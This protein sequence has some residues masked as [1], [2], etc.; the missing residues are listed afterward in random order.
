LNANKRLTQINQFV[1]ERGFASVAELSMLFHVSEM[2]VRRDLD[3]LAE[4]NRVKRIYGGAAT[5][6]MSPPLKSEEI[7]PL[8]PEELLTCRV[9]ILVAASL[10]PKLGLLFLDPSS[11]L[12]IPVISEALPQQNARTCVSI[13]DYQAGLAFGRWAG[14]YALEHWGGVGKVLDLTYH[15]SNTEA[16]SRGFI[17]GLRE[18]LPGLRE[19]LSLNPQSRY[20]LAYQ[21]TRDALTVH[22]DF[23]IILAINDTNASAAVDACRDLRIDPS[24]LI[25]LSFGLEGDTLKNALV[26]GPYYKA[27]LAMF[28]EIVGP[29]CVKAAI[30]AYNRYPLPDRIFTPFRI[31]T[32]ENLTDYYLPTEEGW[33]LNGQA[34][35][36][37]LRVAHHFPAQYDSYPECIGIILPFGEHEWYR[38]LVSSMQ[39]YAG[40]FG[41]NIEIVDTEQTI[42]KEIELRQRDIARFAISLIEPNDV[43]FIDGGAITTH[44]AQ[45]L[46]DCKD[47]TVITNSIPAFD[48]LKNNPEITL[49]STG[50]VLRKVSQVLVGPTAE[51]SLHELRADK[52]FLTV[53]GISLDFG[54]SHTNI[55]EV[56]IK[57]TMLR[58][59][60][61]VILL[62]DHTC[63]GEESMIQIAPLK[64]IHKLVSDNALAASVRLNLS[65][66]GIQVLIAS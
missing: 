47:L 1:D 2:T 44:L 53:S 35:L 21:L 5:N 50:G 40:Q 27:G 48:I 30:A 52:L 7:E 16:R 55:S 26:A 57:Q 10:N 28:P 60:R 61:E 36:A 59:A 29:T 15:F 38:N 3:K 45:F 13:D 19:V 51:K 33:Q 11:K 9:D 12:H 22:G 23:N 14:H 54:L 56:T 64:A 42:K 32:Q 49:I 31:L 20:E 58:T 17:N 41:I 63:F 66:L 6:R 65:R 46:V 25:V 18:V 4:L 39:A 34:A 8:S 62:A 24:S 43:I 37:E